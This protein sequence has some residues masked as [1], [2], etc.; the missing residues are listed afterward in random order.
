MRLNNILGVAFY[1]VTILSSTHCSAPNAWPFIGNIIGFSWFWRKLVIFRTR[2]I[3]KIERPFIKEYLRFWTNILWL[4][5]DRLVEFSWYFLDFCRF[6]RFYL[7]FFKLFL[8]FY[9][10]VILH[11]HLHIW[12]ILLQASYWPWNEGIVRCLP[13]RHITVCWKRANKKLAKG[14]NHICRWSWSITEK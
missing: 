7:C 4:L 14:M 5:L 10:S 11:G 8:L 3:Y 13:L 12:F 2:N 6:N 1:N 9:F